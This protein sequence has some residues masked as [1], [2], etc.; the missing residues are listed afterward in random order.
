MILK[1]FGCE[2]FAGITDREYKLDGHMNVIV[3]D[4]ESG[5]TTMLDMIYHVLNT[6]VD[7]KRNDKKE[8][9]EKYMP[10]ERI[11]GFSGDCIDGT[12]E[13][14][15]ESGVFTVGKEWSRDEE[16][17]C[18]MKESGGPVIKAK[19]NVE[20]RMREEL[21]FGQAVYRNIIFSSQ[22]EKERILRGILQ[23]SEDGGVKEAK[24][25]LASRVT[26]TVMELDGVSIEE[27]GEK[28]AE[29]IMEYESNWDSERNQPKSKSRAGGGRWEK[30]VGKI[31]QSYYAMKDKEM[32]REQAKEAEYDYEQARTELEVAKD[33]FLSAAAEQKEYEEY[34]RDIGSRRKNEELASSYAREL[35]ECMVA[36]EK[37]PEL[38]GQYEK[39]TRLKKELEIAERVSSAKEKYEKLTEY[40][41]K[42][43][44]LK[45]R[46]KQAHDVSKEEYERAESCA[47]ELKRIKRVM[48]GM[49]G[50]RGKIKVSPDV[51]VQISQGADSRPV[52][53]QDGVFRIDEAFQVVVPDVMELQISPENVNIDEIRAEFQRRSEEQDAILV[54]YGLERMEQLKENYEICRQLREEIRIEEASLN[55]FLG[56]DTKDQIEADYKESTEGILA[57]SQNDFQNAADIRDVCDIRQEVRSIC[58]VERLAETMGSLGAELDRLE[59][60]YASVEDLDKKREELQERMEGLQAETGRMRQIPEKYLSIGDTEEARKHYQDVC[61]AAESLKKEKETL[62]IQ[63]ERNLPEKTFEEIEPEYENAKD[64]L[65]KNME[66]CE[67]W[68]HILSVFETTRKSMEKSPSADILENTKKYLEAVTDGKVTVNVVED[69]LDVD[70]ISHGSVMNYQLLSEGTKET[71]SLAFRLA[72]LENLYGTKKGFA[73]FDDVMLDMD[74]L[75]RKEAAELLKEFSKKYQVIYLTCDPRFGELLGGNVIHV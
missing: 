42:L 44:E 26:Q 17:S 60:T 37:W 54:A 69:S 2:Q 38:S 33:A 3:G 53:V 40:E 58:E 13:F 64:E 56:D 14:E 28:I 5:K 8:F 46:L 52:P 57:D 65:K 36:A 32:E 51:P 68:K 23:S 75:R 12:V 29:K 74:P 48:E 18:R 24:G 61:D 11:S 66:L 1:K 16:S 72:V 6:G 22:N 31:L 59:R 41:G 25:E 45:T 27:L 35:K 7:L 4:N 47:H 55:V 10:A 30:N 20:E 21:E 70:V 34:I 71:V 62:C 73:V 9:F 49:S 43:D 19:K 39:L 50:L 63:C 15:S 67:H